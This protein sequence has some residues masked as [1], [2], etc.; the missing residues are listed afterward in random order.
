MKSRLSLDVE[1]GAFAEQTGLSACGHAQAGGDRRKLVSGQ[2][3]MGGKMNKNRQKQSRLA[4][5]AGAISERMPPGRRK[6]TLCIAAAAAIAVMTANAVAGGL[7]LL[8]RDG[9]RLDME[10]HTV[11][12]YQSAFSQ[13][14]TLLQMVDGEMTRTELGRTSPGFQHAMGNIGWRLFWEDYL[15]VFFDATMA[16]QVAAD[17]WWGH[18][19]YMLI[20]RMPEDSPVAWVN[21][22]LNHIDVKAGQFV[23]DFGNELYRRSYNADVQSNPLV[24][25]P[26]VSPHATEVGVEIRHQNPAG[27]GAM[28]GTGSGVATENFGRDARPSYRGKIWLGDPG[29]GGLETAA[30]F[31][32]T[33]HGDKVTRGSNLF[34]TERLGGQ[35]AGI[36]DDGNAPGQVMLGDGTHLTAWQLD[37]GWTSAE[38]GGIWSFFGRVDDDRGTTDETWY[39]YGITGQFYLVPRAVYLAT[40]YSSADAQRFQ[41]SKDNDGRLD[42]WQIGGGVHLFRG[43]QL[44]VEYVEQRTRGFS[45]GS[46]SGISLAE[47]PRFSGAIAEI[48]YSF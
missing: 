30:S 24:G 27:L 26:I 34:R 43:A 31:Y 21:P 46:L 20:R 32:R 37:A 14:A 42:R 13:K 18:Q 48:S 19:G 2:K 40:R 25:N 17:K 47:N 10:V 9:V 11:G 41:G 5:Y 44:K 15:E 38:R 3:T 6:Q 1:D 23:V 36:W 12:R 29:S 16:S 7:T 28:V 45:G 33:H 4:G 8:E 39:Y 22:V 35:Y